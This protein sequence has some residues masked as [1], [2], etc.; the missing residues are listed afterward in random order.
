MIHDRDPQQDAEANELT[1][2]L[3]R[4]LGRR[5]VLIGTVALAVGV[6]AVALSYLIQP[7]FTATATL[8]PQTGSSTTGLMAAIDLTGHGAR[9]VLLTTIKEGTYK[10]Y[11]YR[12]KTTAAPSQERPA[13]TALNFTLY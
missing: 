9:D 2:L 5:A 7:Q 12:N 10:A 6:A 4:T 11:L 13:G 3:L 8:L 1:W